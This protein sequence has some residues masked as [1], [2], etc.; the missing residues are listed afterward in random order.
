MPIQVLPPAV[1]ERIAAGEVIERPA[2]VVKELIENSIDAG[3]TEIHVHLE[4]GGKALIEITDNGSGM[5]PKDLRLCIERHATSKLQTLDDLEKIATLGFRG[6]ALPSVAAVSDL[7]ILSRAKNSNTTYELKVTPFSR[8]KSQCDPI[9]F[10]H[11]LNSPHGTRMR[12]VGLF[13]QIPARLKFL[14]SQAAE[15]S[16]VREWVERLALTHSHI[17]FKLTSNERTLV[18]LRPAEESARVREILGDGADFPLV[19][20]SS[21]EDSP[22]HGALK[23]RLHWLQGLSLPQTRRLVQVV[24]GR[25][26]RDRMLQQA[27]LSSFKQ[28]LMPGQFPALALFVEVDPALLDL[29]VHPTKT[30]I[31][32]LN[33]REI[34]HEIQ[35]LVS[36]MIGQAG[37]PAYV[38]SLNSVAEPE[39]FQFEAQAFSFTPPAVSTSQHSPYTTHSTSEAAQN[40]AL[41][42]VPLHPLSGARFA[43]FLFNTYLL[44]DLGQELAL[45]DQHAAHERIRFEKLKNR[46]FGANAQA[47]QTQALLIPESVT[48]PAEFKSHV[49]DRLPLL[50]SLGFEVELFSEDTVLFRGIPPEWGNTQLRTRLKN[51]IERLISVEGTSL[52]MDE[53]LFEKLASEACHSAVRAGDHLEP[54]EAA[55]IVEQLFKCEH[56]WNCPHGRPTL[57]KIPQARLEEWFIRRV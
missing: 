53:A 28:A 3:A 31:R 37:A 17:G 35:S 21:G 34:F 15:V 26:L 11:F 24:N 2:S 5:E 56:P 27:L 25:A 38:P 16:Q 46:M 42:S 40:T 57:V 23:L 50:S 36:Q 39:R 4:D 52:G 43:G 9:T 30:E 19:S 14:K 45:V 47:P 7:T 20:I 12:A 10:G 44:Y 55:S 41:P 29:N 48:F 1:A 8:D 54:L 49:L 13:S 32:F 51:L 22:I 18:N 33:S 6:E